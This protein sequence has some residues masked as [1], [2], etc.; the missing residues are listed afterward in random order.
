[1]NNKN[2]IGSP[3]SKI[4]ADNHQPRTKRSSRFN[5]YEHAEF[6]NS[7]ASISSEDKE[8]TPSTAATILSQPKEK[9]NKKNPSNLDLPAS[10]FKKRF[11]NKDYEEHSS[12][13]ISSELDK[14]ESEGTKSNKKKRI[15]Q[16]QVH[17]KL[18]NHSISPG[19]LYAT[20]SGRLFHAGKILIV[21][22]GLPARSKT[23]LGV[24]LTR[25]LRWL[26]VRTQIFHASDY[27]RN[28]GCI[29]DEDEYNSSSVDAKDKFNLDSLCLDIE[30]VT[31]KDTNT[32]KKA[33]IAKR[34]RF[35]NKCLNDID[36]FFFDDNNSQ[37]AIYDA[38]NI[39]VEERDMLNQRYSQG[40]KGHTM[41]CSV[42]FIE[43]IVNDA[44][45]LKRNI[46]I[47]VNSK[48]YDG[49]S[50]ARALDHFMQRIQRN[51]K[52]YVEMGGENENHL[53]FVKYIDYGETLYVNNS[54]HSYLINKII[55]FL[56]NLKEKK[57]RV[58]LSRCGNSDYD[59]YNDDE[60]LNGRGIDFAK[61]MTAV[62]I[63]RINTLRK[64][65]ELNAISPASPVS[66]NEFSIDDLRT[67]VS[68]DRNMNLGKVNK[69]QI[70]RHDGSDEDSVV[71]FSAPRKRTY[72]TA[73]FFLKKGITVRKKL[74]LK[75]LNPGVIADMSLDEVKEKYPDEFEEFLESPYFYRFSK[76]ESYHDLAL[77]MGSLIFEVERMNGDVIIIAHESALRIIYGY[78]MA[79]SAK[80]IPTLEFD[81]ENVIEISFGH[82]ENKAVKLPIF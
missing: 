81:R 30:Y 76:G 55:S 60:I 22:V 44:E 51:N 4:A 1:M 70:S 13:N 75:Q 34:R 61:K 50:H 8:I 17:V 62:V 80:D 82:Y 2:H 5:I 79:K 3:V 37:I 52:V 12:L 33:G 56:M 49:W 53:S 72:D 78:L 74:E 18:S 39:T 45:L 35:I 63:N 11:G 69:R 64:N 42:L 67:Q 16:D 58:Y 47:A 29:V 21:L 36:D 57:G 23:K 59:K 54:N 27:R 38:L 28:E 40:E 6:S 43:S 65:S 48:D 41:G 9:T 7:N 46:E 20:E 68:V 31:D 71:V 26:G 25:Y 15:L 32:L 14:I 66:S 77:R 19:Q 73:Q 24:A 10:M